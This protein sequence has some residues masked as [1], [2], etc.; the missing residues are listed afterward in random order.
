MKANDALVYDGLTREQIHRGFV[1]LVGDHVRRGAEFSFDQELIRWEGPVPSLWALHELGAILTL[2]EWQ[3]M[4]T[5]RSMAPE[6]EHSPA[7][8]GL[9]LTVAAS[10]LYRQ[11][12]H[13]RNRPVGSIGWSVI[14][15]RLRNE[16]WWEIGSD[17]ACSDTDR[18]LGRIRVT[19]DTINA[20][21]RLL[22]A[23]RGL[24]DRPVESASLLTSGGRQ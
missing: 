2:K 21:A 9:G 6:L 23:C 24:G 5:L 13:T 16:D 10:F 1:T 15:M 3:D 20:F 14:A 19:E 4:G 12:A 22:W 7:F 18:L 11:A 8:F 17:G